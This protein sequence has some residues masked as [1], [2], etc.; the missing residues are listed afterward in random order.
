MITKRS[1]ILKQTCSWKLQVCL[2]MWTF[3]LP[4]GIK[5]L[6]M[7]SNKNVDC[8]GLITFWKKQHEFYAIFKAN[9]HVAF[10]IFWNKIISKWG[11]G[12]P[13]PFSWFLFY[14]ALGLT[15]LAEWGFKTKRNVTKSCISAS[16]SFSTLGSCLCSFSCYYCYH[17]QC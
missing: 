8:D 11:K 7:I 10:K 12:V 6:R 5:G 4:P 15:K 17:F 1:H 3:L 13:C 9:Y 2:S 16:K 14:N